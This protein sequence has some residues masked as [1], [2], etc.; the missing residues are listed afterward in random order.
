MSIYAG[1]LAAGEST[2]MGSPKALLQFQGK[3]FLEHLVVTLRNAGLH[4]I[5]ML[6]LLLMRIIKKGNSL[7]YKQLSKVSPTIAMRL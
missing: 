7:R 2:R 5:R 3:T 4:E 1:I 6:D